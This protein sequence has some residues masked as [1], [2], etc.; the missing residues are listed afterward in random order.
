[1]SRKDREESQERFFSF[2]A[3][4]AFA[5]PL[6]EPPCRRLTRGPGAVSLEPPYDCPELQQ[7]AVRRS[8]LSRERRAVDQSHVQRRAPR[9]HAAAKTGTTKRSLAGVGRRRR[10]LRPAIQNGPA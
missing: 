2:A 5:R 9:Q 3:L 10:L 4:A 1:M 7:Q 8:E 6:K